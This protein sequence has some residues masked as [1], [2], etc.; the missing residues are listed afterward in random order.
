MVHLLFKFSPIAALLFAT[1]GCAAPVTPDA[2]TGQAPLT[3]H[4]SAGPVSATCAESQC[5]ITVDGEEVIEVMHFGSEADL[6]SP[7]GAL[8]TPGRDLFLISES[9]GDG[10]AS[11]NRVL[12]TG[13][14]VQVTEPFGN[15]EAISQ[16]EFT[17][18]VVFEYPS[19]RFSLDGADEVRRPRQRW[20][21]NSACRL[22]QIE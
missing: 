4:S 19:A 17:T 21:V 13:R 6:I 8:G 7:L 16:A 5:R 11:M 14:T 18:D 1:A 12:C 2:P 9:H 15:C 3:L 20:E 22:R 10:C